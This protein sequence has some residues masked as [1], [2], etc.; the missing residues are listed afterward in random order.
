M[1]C[2]SQKCTKQIRYNNYCDYSVDKYK[3]AKTV[4]GVECC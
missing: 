4:T 2:V 1:K 3:N